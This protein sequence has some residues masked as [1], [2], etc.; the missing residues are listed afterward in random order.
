MKKLKRNI[1]MGFRVT[2]EE[3]QW[4][5]ERMKQANISSLRV[6]LLKMAVN[7]WVVNLDLTEVSECS[8]LLKTV[9]NNVNQIAKFTNTVG[10]VHSTDME[11]IQAHLDAVWKQQNKILRS[12]TKMLEAV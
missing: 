12:L 5:H 6:Y 1:N 10:S 9:S 8:R 11:K 4:I 2:E 3:Q 7:G